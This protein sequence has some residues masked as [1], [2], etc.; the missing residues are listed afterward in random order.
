MREAELPDGTVLEFPDETSDD[1]MDSVVKQHISGSPQPAPFD[2]GSAKS[3]AHEVIAKE[4]EKRGFFGHLMAKMAPGT[5]ENVEQ[6]KDIA[7]R[8]NI[9]ETSLPSAVVQEGGVLAKQALEPLSAITPDFIEEGLGAIGGAILKGASNLPSN[10]PSAPT[11]G[12][13][14]AKQK[15]AL[16]EIDPDIA[17]NI[18]AVANIGGVVAGGRY[19]KPAA[20]GVGKVASDAVV[21]A[22]KAIPDIKKTIAP[23]KY[24]EDFFSES[25]KLYGEL[26]KSKELV[27]IDFTNKYKKMMS[28][29]TPKPIKG[30]NLTSEEKKLKKHLDEL[31][32]LVPRQRTFDEIRR[33]D[34]A[35]TDKIRNEVDVMGNMSPMGEKLMGVR[36]KFRGMIDEIPDMPETALLNKAKINYSAAKMLE[37]LEDAADRAAR[38]SNEAKALQ[39]E[40]AKLLKDKSWGKNLPEV[41]DMLEK[42]AREHLGDELLGVVANRISPVIMGAAGGAGAAAG[43]FAAG[44]ASRSAKGRMVAGRGMNVSKQIV[45]EAGKKAEAAKYKVSPQKPLLQIPPK[46]KLSPLP[47]TQEEIGIAKAKM[48]VQEK[49][50]DKPIISG[51]SMRPVPTP[52]QLPPKL[53]P[54]PQRRIIVDNK[55]NMRPELKD[56]F[57]AAYNKI[58]DMQEKGMSWGTM[59]ASFDRDMRQSIQKFEGYKAYNEAD[60]QKEINAIF[61]SIREDLRK[62]IRKSKQDVQELKTIKGERRNTALTEAFEKSLDVEKKRK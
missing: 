44:V 51:A 15:Q 17:R 33:I 52:E 6:A 21:G 48:G 11:M 19:A 13:F 59:K 46:E 39:R 55:G 4:L 47:M 23:K 2:Q 60:I 36:S 35:L 28:E 61:A 29:S 57:E 12:E 49:R 45:K 40:Y 14:A 32:P 7:N 56:E 20:E 53:L 37:D 50:P 22:K 54:P 27:P 5:A 18:G 31:S 1:V 16:D 8:Y 62:T 26:S 58:Q 9:G 42:A 10:V 38:S 41:R 25:E 34:S 30:H 3:L 24:S 43:T